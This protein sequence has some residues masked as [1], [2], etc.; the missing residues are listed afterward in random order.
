MFAIVFIYACT[1]Q[2]D[3]AG[4]NLLIYKKVISQTNILPS[5]WI[6][7]ALSADPADRPTSIQ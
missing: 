5:F 1:Y 6:E 2:V 7:V 4:F 3:L